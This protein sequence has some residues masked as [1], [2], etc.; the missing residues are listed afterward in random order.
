M[1]FLQRIKFSKNLHLKAGNGAHLSLEYPV[2]ISSSDDYFI[3]LLS[4]VPS[5]DA[6]A[7]LKDINLLLTFDL[8]DTVLISDAITQRQIPILATF[9][10]LGGGSHTVIQSAG[11]R[12]LRRV[13]HIYNFYMELQSESFIPQISE[14]TVHLD[15]E[16]ALYKRPRTAM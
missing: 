6:L 5:G 15:F 16:L 11:K 13:S 7:R 14:D 12:P 1:E 3:E 9:R 2:S 10:L 8:L 4:V